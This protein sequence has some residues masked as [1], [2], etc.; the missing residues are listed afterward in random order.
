M[1]SAQGGCGA[2]GGAGVRA[3]FAR[4][5]LAGAAEPMASCCADEIPPRLPLPQLSQPTCPS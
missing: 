5:S 2:Q 4:P 3:P 1:V